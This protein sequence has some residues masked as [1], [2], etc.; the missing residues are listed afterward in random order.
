[1]VLIRLPL[2]VRLR[3]SGRS[4][5]TK[6]RWGATCAARTCWS[7]WAGWGEEMFCPQQLGRLIEGL[8]VVDDGPEHPLLGILVVWQHPC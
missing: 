1:M 2:S 7:R 6:L 8:V 4:L 3:Q 5:S